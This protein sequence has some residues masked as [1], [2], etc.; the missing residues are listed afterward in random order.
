MGELTEHFYFIRSQFRRSNNPAKARLNILDRYPY[1]ELV[2][3]RHGGLPVKTLF[4]APQLDKITIANDIGK[5]VIREW[6]GT[7]YRLHL[8]EPTGN[9]V[10]T[11]R[12]YP[13]TYD[14][15]PLGLAFFPREQII[16]AEEN[17]GTRIFDIDMKSMKYLPNEIPL[18]VDMNQRCLITAKDS[19]FCTTAIFG[20]SSSSR[21]IFNDHS[22]QSKTNSWIFA[23]MMAS[24]RLHPLRVNIGKLSSKV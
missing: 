1:E 24:F 7:Q 15:G 3:T 22:Y 23:T 17:E 19:S 16:V 13:Y 20:R 11:S 14:R 4:K 12:W 10:A 9:V 8:I 21:A 18:I 5:P 6:G 2:V